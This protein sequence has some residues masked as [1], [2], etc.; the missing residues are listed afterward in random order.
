MKAWRSFRSKTPPEEY[1]EYL[2]GGREQAF[3][4]RLYNKQMTRLIQGR[5]YAAEDIAYSQMERY[6]FGTGRYR[7][8]TG[9]TLKGEKALDFLSRLAEKS[10]K[11]SPQEA[12]DRLVSKLGLHIVKSKPVSMKPAYPG[13]FEVDRYV[14]SRIGQTYVLSRV[15]Q[16]TKTTTQATTRTVIAPAATSTSSLAKA[17][18]AIT[19]AFAKATSV[20]ETAGAKAVKAS[21]KTKTAGGYIPSLEDIERYTLKPPVGGLKTRGFSGVKPVITP[22]K[23]SDFFDRNLQKFLEKQFN[24]PKQLKVVRPKTVEEELELVTPISPPIPDTIRVTSIREVEKTI[25]DV[26]PIERGEWKTATPPIEDIIL[27]Q[28]ERTIF[29][30]KMFKISPPPPP[31]LQFTPPKMKSRPPPFLRPR[32]KGRRGW[33][34]WELYYTFAMPSRVIRKLGLKLPKPRRSRRRRRKR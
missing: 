5:G 14:M 12:I 8:S 20:A 24:L 34:Y 1:L 33:E 31:S 6:M 26:T 17:S 22:P 3:R 27:P 23:P 16:M 25:L 21:Q 13:V 2:A 4:Y 11:G 19:V 10:G 9:L 28:E 29:P 30:S 15:S 32:K 7:V 18:A